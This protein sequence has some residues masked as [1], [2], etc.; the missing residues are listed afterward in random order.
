MIFWVLDHIPGAQKRTRPGESDFDVRFEWKQW[1]EG[2]LLIGSKDLWGIMSQNLKIYIKT[3][4][5]VKIA[6]SLKKSNKHPP[7]HPNCAMPNPYGPSSSASS[8][9][10]VLYLRVS[11][12]RHHQRPWRICAVISLFSLKFFSQLSENDYLK[13][14]FQVFRSEW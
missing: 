6:A 12:E 2:Q 14:I 5:I 13:V 11:T 9:L 1:F 10:Q 8:M 3:V 7:T 4:K